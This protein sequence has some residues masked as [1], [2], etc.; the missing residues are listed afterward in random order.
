MATNQTKKKKG[1]VKKKGKVVKKAKASSKK[2]TLGL[3]T[4][5]L[6]H[7]YRREQKPE[8][9]KVEKKTLEKSNKAEQYF[10]RLARDTVEIIKKRSLTRG[11]ELH[12]Q[13]TSENL[14]SVEFPEKTTNELQL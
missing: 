7:P 6:T 11:A 12:I 3:D 4:L 10:Q 1:S 5:H 13:E 8:E 9:K 14:K 2:K